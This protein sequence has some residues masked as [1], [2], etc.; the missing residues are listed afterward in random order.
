[1]RHITAV[2]RQFIRALV[3]V[4]A[5]LTLLLGTAAA[6]DNT[7]SPPAGLR[8]FYTGHSFH[9][10]VPRN[11]E[12]LVKSAG[13][14]GHKLVGTQGIG[15]S[16][17]IQHW[18]LE[19]GK[20]KAKPALASGE[21]DVFT[22]AAH[23]A[24]PDEGITRF[25]EL[26]LKHNP[27]MRF[28]VQASWFPHDVP[29][30]EKRIRDNAIRDNAQVKDLQAAVDGWRKKLEAQVDDL[31]RQHARRAVFIVPVGDAVVK[32]R[33]LVI[34]GKYPGRSK[35]SELFRD[36]IGHGYG[37]VQALAS[38]CNFAAI[39]RRSPVGL[40]MAVDGVSEEQ[41]AILQRIAWE[42]VSVYGYA[43]I[44]GTEAVRQ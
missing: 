29:E 2:T 11:I 12:Q 40:T 6:G 13:I 19:E 35:Q 16:R 37:D 18:D 34:E 25:V 5:A 28:L 38:Y 32:L 17:V 27:Q 22:M 3:G 15:G 33:G 7:Q 20:N 36:P 41:H 14:E 24:I 39:Y 43:W 4:S 8:V 23:V 21:V 42:T 26:G 10:F 9:M 31:N 1:M 30:P 44:A